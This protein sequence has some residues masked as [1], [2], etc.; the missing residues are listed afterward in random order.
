[1]SGFYS[2]YSAASFR[3]EAHIYNYCIYS[4]VL[5]QLYFSINMKKLPLK[6]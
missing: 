6:D 5:T 1:M 4:R 2:A 3:C